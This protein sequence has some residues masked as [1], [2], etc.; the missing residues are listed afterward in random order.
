MSGLNT[1][2]TFGIKQHNSK[3]NPLKECVYSKAKKEK[4]L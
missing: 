4:L 1:T 3:S 2:F